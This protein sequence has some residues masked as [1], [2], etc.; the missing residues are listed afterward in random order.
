V[1]AKNALKEQ[2]P[3]QLARVLD[4]IKRNHQELGHIGEEAEHGCHD[5]AGNGDESQRADG[6][7][8]IFKH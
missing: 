1:S 5:Q 3:T 6:I 2:H 4:L 8:D 7:T